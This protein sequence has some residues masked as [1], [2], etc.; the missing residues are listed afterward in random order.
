VS[1][2]AAAPRRRTVK[3]RPAGGRAVAALRA[4]PRGFWACFVVA[5]LNACIWAVVTP[6][7][8]VPDEIPHA[9]YVQYLA[10]TGDVPRPFN[11]QAGN[12]DPSE[13]ERV[14]ME[15][16]PFSY[17]GTPNWDRQ[18]DRDAQEALS[19]DLD[20]EHEPAA[21]AAA[22][23]PPL[24]YALEAIPYKLASGGSFYDRLLAMR[25][26]SALFAGLTA[27]FCFL[28]ARE[29]VP[30]SPWAW[31]AAGTAVALQPLASFVSGGVNP[32]A[33]LY[34]ASAALFY[35][36]ARA[37][38][39][40]LTVRTGAAIGAAL[41]V[42]LLSKGT[43]LGFLPAI[44][45]V[46]ALLVWRAP[47]SARRTALKGAAAA[48]AAGAGP[49]LLWLVVSAVVYDRSG[50]TA[51]AG[52][53]NAAPGTGLKMQLSYV[54]QVYLPRLPFMDDQFPFNVPKVIWFDGFVGRL[55]YSSYEFPGWYNGIALAVAAALSVLA[56]IALF[57]RR[58]AVLRR[59][60]EA[61]SYV[62][63]AGAIMFVVGFAG[64]RLAAGGGPVLQARYLLPLL[65]LYAGLI[66]L[67]ARAPGRRFGPAVAVLIVVTLAAHN[68]AA[69]MLSLH[70]YYT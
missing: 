50:S 24:Y 51:T 37:F 55:G 27:G 45:L 6:S 12:L 31:I 70:Q 49:Y 64:Y 16:V 28:F 20:R 23:Y 22:P 29:L 33:L 15:Y 48:V 40:G 21:G 5:T 30:G 9:A 67:A 44:A 57:V 53:A 26:F 4:V 63:M 60:P 13:E 34:A 11:T 17:Q 18:A 62:A 41:A 66:A 1:T 59:W 42:A 19:Q 61:L 56:A 39:R 54:W 52:L 7:F 14:A 10:E 35:A 8:Q 47:A 68:L 46:L 25:L 36:V 38:R 2:E 58:G 3:M 32:E 43:A 69:L 65:A